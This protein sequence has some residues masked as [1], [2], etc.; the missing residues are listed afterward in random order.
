M[1]D[2]Y[3][4]GSNN[5]MQDA[6]NLDGSL[7]Y[8][9]VPGASAALKAGTNITYT[10]GRGDA[11]VRVAGSHQGG[12]GGMH[13]LFS[14]LTVDGALTDAGAGVVGIRSWASN[15]VHQALG[16]V[17]GGQFVARHYA[18]TPVHMHAEASLIGLE[19]IGYCSGTAGVGT[20]MGANVVIRSYAAA[21]YAG[22]VHRGVQ[23]IVD[24]A[25]L[26]ADE[27]TALCIWN[28]GASAIGGLR[29]VGADTMAN[30]LYLDAFGG[31]A[32]QAT[33]HGSGGADILCDAYLKCSVGGVEYD[34]PLY[35]S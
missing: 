22:G 6:I 5:P 1:S 3:I 33:R 8:L 16:N 31:A 26:G 10:S 13:S 17:Y 2:D 32:I 9:V 4:T 27:V 25:T 28:M 12:A 14:Y 18:A 21:A 29:I 30:F 15:T 34:I 11:A 24:E 20:M 35:N 23:I 19:A 7:E